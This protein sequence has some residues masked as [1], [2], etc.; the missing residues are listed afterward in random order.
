M[1]ISKFLVA[2]AILFGGVSGIASSARSRFECKDEGVYG[3]SCYGTIHWRR[4][5]MGIYPGSRGITINGSID[6]APF[7][8]TCAST[9]IRGAKCN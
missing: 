5:F 2:A 9:S 6:G 4:V 8:V 7:S 1:K 3:I